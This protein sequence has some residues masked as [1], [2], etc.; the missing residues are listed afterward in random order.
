MGESTSLVKTK[1]V[2]AVW[3][4]LQDV[5]AQFGPTLTEK[6]FSFFVTLGKEFGANPFLREIWAVKYDQ[7]APASIFL[8][9]DMYRRRAQEIPE[10]NGH[11]VQAIYEK[12]KFEFDIVNEKPK[13]SY[14]NFGDRGRLLGA[15]YIGWSKRSEHPF[16]VSVR[17]DEYNQGFALWKSKPETQIKKVAEAQG[18]RGQYQ[19]IFAGTYDESEQWAVENKTIS[20]KAS[21]PPPPLKSALDNPKEHDARVRKEYKEK[22]EKEEPIEAT[23][24]PEPEPVQSLKD[25]IKQGNPAIESEPPSREPGQDDD[26]E[27]HT[28]TNEENSVEGLKNKIRNSAA[29]HFP[30]PNAFNLWLKTLTTNEEKGYH[31]LDGIDQCRSFSQARFIIG[32][33]KRKAGLQ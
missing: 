23:A 14:S 27:P 17:F 16:Y 29:E 3:E 22:I 18:L 6:E 30:N 9:R 7:K 24:T 10:Y 25:K 12:D 4:N 20:A 32:Q 11:T 13:H 2:M 1:N 21:I 8:G 5:R 19:G 15:Y 26:E 28:V 31:G 33:L